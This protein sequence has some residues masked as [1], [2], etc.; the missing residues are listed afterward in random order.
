M[1]NCP[2]KKTLGSR[3]LISKTQADLLEKVFRLLGNRTRLRILHS[4][5]VS[6]RLCVS[7]LSASIGMKPQAVSNQLQ[8]MLDKNILLATREGNNIFY[9]IN[10]PCVMELLEK[11]LCLV[12]DQMSSTGWFNV[13]S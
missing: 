8:R 12:E 9:E 3:G 11:G 7:D 5:A 1:Q 10:D 4:L 13:V 2:P 6:K